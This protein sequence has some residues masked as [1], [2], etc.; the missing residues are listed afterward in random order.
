MITAYTLPLPS[1]ESK[2]RDI[3]LQDETW[4]YV[5]YRVGLYSVC[6]CHADSDGTL[7]LD[8][9]IIAS[10][11]LDADYVVCCY[12]AIVKKVYPQ[13]HNIVVGDWDSITMLE[14]DRDHINITPKL[15]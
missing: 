1:N 11:H 9:N 3:Q 10:L 7:L 5:L 8:D 6:L 15:Q 2:A 13:L 14:W 4:N 12:P